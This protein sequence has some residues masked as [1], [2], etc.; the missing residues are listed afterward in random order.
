MQDS[1]LNAYL[2][3]HNMGPAGSYSALPDVIHHRPA[4]LAAGHRALRPARSSP[5][6]LPVAPKG[7]V[8][9]FGAW[10]WTSHRTAHRPRGPHA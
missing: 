2:R 3:E 4:H 10:H 5:A 8:H 7:V 9:G 6:R 1:P